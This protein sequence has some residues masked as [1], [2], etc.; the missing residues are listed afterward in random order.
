ML[1]FKIIPC[2][3]FFW[4]K[5]PKETFETETH[6]LNEAVSEFRCGFGS[7]PSPLPKVATYAETAKRSFGP[8]TLTAL[9][10]NDSKSRRPSVSRAWDVGFRIPTPTRITTASPFCPLAAQS[11]EG[12]VGYIKTSFVISTEFR[13]RWGR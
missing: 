13:N 6:G 10:V 12:V 11:M 8:P 5:V 4:K 1:Y 2:G 9:R 3:T 7:Q